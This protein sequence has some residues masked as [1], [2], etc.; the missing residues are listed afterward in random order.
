M[1]HAVVQSEMAEARRELRTQYGDFPNAEELIRAH[2]ASI[3]PEVRRVSQIP[4]NEEAT[5]ELDLSTIEAPEGTKVIDA[6]VRGNAISYV[7]EDA[8][9]QWLRGVQAYDESYA[10]PSEAEGEALMRRTAMGDVALRQKALDLRAEMQLEMKKLRQEL[11]TKH[12]EEIA[13]L[14]EEHA[15]EVE[16]LRSD[17]AQKSE[18]EQSSSGTSKSEKQMQ[19]QQ[20][21]RKVAEG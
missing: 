19:K 2:A 10:P 1:S 6:V 14:R 3:S 21:R 8:S 20:A 15:Q 9:G 4:V 13:K 11:G 16:Q 18:E 17:I 7:Y 5:R 12:A